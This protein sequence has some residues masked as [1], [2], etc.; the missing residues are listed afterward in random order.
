MYQKAIGEQNLDATLEKL[1]KK[2][3]VIRSMAQM[4]KDKVNGKYHIDPSTYD[5]IGLI[6]QAFEKAQKRAWAKVRKDPMSPRTSSTKHCSKC[7]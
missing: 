7:G 2:P 6:S 5:H 1:S 3:A 4:E